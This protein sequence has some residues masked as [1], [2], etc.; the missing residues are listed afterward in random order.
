METKDV[1]TKEPC[2]CVGLGHAVNFCPL[3]EA[4]SDLLKACRAAE[5]SFGVGQ[6]DSPLQ[7]RLQAVIAKAEGR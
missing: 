1:A 3:H 5:A 7:A 2:G 4:A 6:T